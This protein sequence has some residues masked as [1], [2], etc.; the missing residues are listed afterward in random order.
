MILTAA[1]LWM[2]GNF[3]VM[4]LMTIIYFKSKKLYHLFY[5]LFHLFCAL[6]G[7]TVPAINVPMIRDF[8]GVVIPIVGIFFAL[9]A[10][11]FKLEEMILEHK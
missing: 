11:A 10:N 6:W 4:F 1:F 7:M 2:V 5:A 8:N 3:I 9:L